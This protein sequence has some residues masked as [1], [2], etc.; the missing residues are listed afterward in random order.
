MF[1]TQNQ[2][3]N[4]RSSKRVYEHVDPSSLAVVTL[5]SL[6]GL[7]FLISFIHSSGSQYLQVGIIFKI[8]HG[9]QVVVVFFFFSCTFKE[10]SLVHN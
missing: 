4:S 8:N 6:L 5:R 10:T 7:I 9:H 3:M 1:Y 2:K